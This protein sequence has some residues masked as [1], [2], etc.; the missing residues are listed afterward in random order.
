MLDHRAADKR[1]QSVNAKAS[2][3]KPKASLAGSWAPTKGK[4]TVKKEELDTEP[5][6][7]L[8]DDGNVTKGMIYY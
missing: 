6:E 5:F 2:S 3:S 7:S 4:V 1:G 8:F